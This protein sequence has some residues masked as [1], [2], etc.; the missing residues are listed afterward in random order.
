MT[1]PKL[2][3]GQRLFLCVLSIFV[4]FAASL[5][6]FQQSRER[7]Y[8]RDALNSQLQEYNYRIFSEMERKGMDFASANNTLE[9]FPNDNLRLTIIGENGN[10]LLDSEHGEIAT[11]TNHS[12]RIEIREAKKN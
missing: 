11:M 2:H 3:V 12:D 8:K 10:V 1:I 7:Q 6:L 9:T 4:I 5:I